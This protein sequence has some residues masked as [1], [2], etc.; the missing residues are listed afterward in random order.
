LVTTASA[1]V[2]LLGF[3]AGDTAPTAAA[4]TLPAEAYTSP[5]VLAWEVAELFARGWLCVARSSE[6][7]EP[8]DQRAVRAGDDAV[9]LVRGQDAVLRGFFNVCRHRGH[10]LLPCGGA[11]V[12]RRA[13]SCPY[14]AWAYGLDGSL[15]STPN[16]GDLPL[17]DP[18]RS[19]LNPARVAEW[20]GWVFV[21]VD[22]NAPALDAY[23]AD[24][25]ELVRPYNPA[26]LVVVSSHEYTVEANWKILNENYNECL[27][28]RTIHPELVK[29]SAADSG[30]NYEP[31]GM[32]VGGTM[33]LRDHAETMSRNGRGGRV[34]PG[35]TEAVRREVRYVGLFPNL[36]ISL[37]PDY[38]MTHRLF[39][40][41]PSRTH[42]ECAW[43]SLLENRDD[44]SLHEAIAFWDLTNKQDWAACE[45]VQRG[46]G[47]RGYRP[48][49][50]SEQEITVSQFVALVRASYR[51][52]APCRPE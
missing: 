11:T 42:I 41:S 14:H 23:V 27:H 2:P 9:L 40:L 47:S 20:H 24:L 46:I 8:G 10:E 13:I 37:H 33:D 3:S 38:V 34:L 19:G 48:G 35:L 52:G 7:A 1:P 6:V 44:G 16:F 17:D 36:L 26:Q 50:F 12:H 45:S 29:L 18:V 4:R 25:E 43:L 31:Q 22:G 49:P 39:P 15:L 30:V 51:A 21:N 5:A 32:W 28:C